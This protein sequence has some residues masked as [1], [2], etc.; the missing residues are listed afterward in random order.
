[1]LAALRVKEAIAI[2]DV[3]ALIAELAALSVANI[4]TV[5][6]IDDELSIHAVLTLFPPAKDEITVFAIYRIVDELR[7]LVVARN[8]RCFWHGIVE[9]LKLF[10]KRSTEVVLPAIVERVPLIAP[11]NG[12]VIYS[13]ARVRR[14][15]RYD[16]FLARVAS[17]M[18]ERALVAKAKPPLL[19]AF[20]AKPGRRNEPGIGGE[21][22]GYAQVVIKNTSRNGE[23]V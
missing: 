22:R 20:R 4:Q 10:E 9:V 18:V 16:S 3:D 11:P 21:A 6:A 14:I 1:M 23:L 2:V 19:S 12:V 5:T 17:S 7:V 13:V 8:E 15:D